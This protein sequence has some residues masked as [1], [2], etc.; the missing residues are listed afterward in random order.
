MVSAAAAEAAAVTAGAGGSGGGGAGATS[1][2]TGAIDRWGVGAAAA[3]A[4]GCEALTEWGV[5]REAAASDVGQ[6]LRRLGDSEKSKIEKLAGTAAADGCTVCG[7]GGGASE[8]AGFG[9]GY[10]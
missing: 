9:T 1:V 6:R 10:E 3:G 7:L 5:V 4:A 8:S 2:V